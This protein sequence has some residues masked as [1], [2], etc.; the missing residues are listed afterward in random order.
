MLLDDASDYADGAARLTNSRTIQFLHPLG[1][2]V[3]ALLAAGLRL[4]A[5]VEHPGLTW[6]QIPC[7][8]QDKNGLWCWPDRPWFPLALTI[9]ATKPA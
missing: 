3:G 5:L 6:K 4:D 8:V 1:A 7:L 2:I 9:K